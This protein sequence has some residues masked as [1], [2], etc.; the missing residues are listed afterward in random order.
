MEP[1]FYEV[2]PELA[3]KSLVLLTPLLSQLIPF[4]LSFAPGL[5]KK[6]FL[7]L[8]NLHQSQPDLLKGTKPRPEMIDKS[9]AFS[10]NFLTC[11]PHAAFHFIFVRSR[12]RMSN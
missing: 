10:E 11:P 6:G 1:F 7:F 3:S 9:Q 12:I 8:T 2:S 4:F 5:Q